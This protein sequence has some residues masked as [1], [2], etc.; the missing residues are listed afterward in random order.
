MVGLI[1][2]GL[3]VGLIFRRLF[4]WYCS[5]INQGEWVREDERVVNNNHKWCNAIS[6]I[7][8]N[9][10]NTLRQFLHGQKQNTHTL[11]PSHDSCCDDCCSQHANISLILNVYY[12][13]DFNKKM[14][15]LFWQCPIVKCVGKTLQLCTNS[16]RVFVEMLAFV[17]EA[18]R[19]TKC[20]IKLNGTEKLFKRNELETRTVFEICLPSL[21]IIGV[22]S[23]SSQCCFFLCQ[24]RLEIFVK[25]KYIYHCLRSRFVGFILHSI[26][27][28]F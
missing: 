19:G 14:G 25:P 21:V 6:I 3:L 28:V 17:C 12:F 16:M 22:K 13:E 27:A 10:P 4:S 24:T 26:V 11:K 5:I 2:H 18:R 23:F 15:N 9:K 20:P 7:I 8:F 1:W